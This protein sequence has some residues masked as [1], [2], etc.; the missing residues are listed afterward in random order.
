MHIHLNFLAFAVLLATGSNAVAQR[1]HASIYTN[2]SGTACSKH[3]DD[4][5]TN[6]YTLDCPGI[7]GFR[8]QVLQDDERSSINIVTPDKQILPLDYWE[9]VTH[10]FSTLGTKAEWRVAKAGREAIPVAVI[11]RINA[12]DQTDSEHPIRIPV[13]AIAKVSPDSACVTRTIDANAPNANEQARRFADNE[14]LPC[15]PRES[16]M[17]P[18]MK[19]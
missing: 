15:L 13:L 7:Q 2:L 5:S 19:G 16:E 1:S 17:K 9:V 18:P 10:G 12:L 4:A 3:V 6:A 8:L 11:V 14:H